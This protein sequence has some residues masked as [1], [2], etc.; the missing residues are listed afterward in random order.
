MHILIAEYSN[1]CNYS[2]V[3]REELGIRGRGGNK[4]EGWGNREYG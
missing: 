4:K 3:K 2:I 1:F